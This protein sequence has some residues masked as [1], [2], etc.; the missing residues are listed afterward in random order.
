LSTPVRVFPY[1]KPFPGVKPP[2]GFTAISLAEEND[3]GKIHACLWKGFNH[4]DNPDDDRDSRM[5]M[6]SSPNFR[7]DLTTVIKASNGDYACYG[8]VPEFYYTV[9]FETICHRELGK[10]ELQQ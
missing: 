2:Q 7:K 3:Y 10:K 8:G 6:Q 1:H 5:L 4:G 9:G